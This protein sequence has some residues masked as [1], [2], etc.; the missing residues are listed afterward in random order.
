LN[1][2][3]FEKYIAHFNNK[4]YKELTSYFTPDVTVEYYDNATY[5]GTPARTLHGPEEFVNNYKALHEHT[6]EALEIG[7]FIPRG[8]LLFVELYTEFHTIKDPPVNSGRTWKKG[9]VTIMTNFI[10]YNF[11]GGKMKRIRIAHFR[12]HDPSEARL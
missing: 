11:E 8:D 4:R 7:A 3:E 2:K 1:R 12:M 10:L 5:T 6:R 9:D